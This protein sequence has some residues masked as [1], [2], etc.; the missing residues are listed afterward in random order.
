MRFVFSSVI[1]PIKNFNV[2]FKWNDRNSIVYPNGAVSIW[3]SVWD[4][5]EEDPTAAPMRMPAFQF[6]SFMS[7]FLSLSLFCYIYV[8]DVHVCL[9]KSMHWQTDS[10]KQ[11]RLCQMDEL[12]VIF[13]C[14]EHHHH[15]FSFVTVVGLRDICFFH[16]SSNERILLRRV[17]ISLSPF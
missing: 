14:L 4:C 11:D 7:I 12:T 10:S 9:E 13:S 15:L 6:S 5:F 16:L 17:H 1:Y 8:S 2:Y 3:K